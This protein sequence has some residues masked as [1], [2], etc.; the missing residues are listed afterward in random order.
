M[1]KKRAFV[2]GAGWCSPGCRLP[3]QRKHE[4]Q[5]GRSGMAKHCFEQLQQLLRDKLDP[6]RLVL[7]LACGRHHSS[8]F[9]DEL[10]DNARLIIKMQIHR[11]GTQLDLDFA[12]NDAGRI[13]ATF[14]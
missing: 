9:D 3:E 14:G 5:D 13:R 7:E 1:G 10:L 6:R 8:P 2:D 12:V 11:F 4:P